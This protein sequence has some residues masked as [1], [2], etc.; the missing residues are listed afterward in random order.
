MCVSPPPAHLQAN[1]TLRMARIW[2]R[3]W[4]DM[5]KD[6]SR[7]VVVAAAT[8]REYIWYVFN[9]WVIKTMSFASGKGRSF[10]QYICPAENE[11]AA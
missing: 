8:N 2:R 7:L 3:V 9:R 4:S 10:L 5:G 1:N 11:C 6:T